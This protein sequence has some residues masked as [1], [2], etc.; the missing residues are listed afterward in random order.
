M[1]QETLHLTHAWQ[2][3]YCFLFANF[4]LQKIDVSMYFGISILSFLGKERRKE[5]NNVMVVL[6]VISNFSSNGVNV[7]NHLLSVVRMLF[8]HLVYVYSYV[9][10]AP[11]K[12]ATK[13]KSPFHAPCV[14]RICFK[15]KLEVMLSRTKWVML[16]SCKRWVQKGSRADRCQ[17]LLPCIQLPQ[18][19][20]HSRGYLWLFID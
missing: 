11:T 6:L 17:T 9:S 3:H 16:H 18:V 13:Q 14:Y 1:A 2:T 12:N 4:Q 7:V 19:F 5:K 8:M 15:V 10:I 20:S